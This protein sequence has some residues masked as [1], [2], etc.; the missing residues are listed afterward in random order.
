[1]LPGKCATGI[2]E[3]I[4]PG[5]RHDAAPILNRSAQKALERGEGL[6]QFLVDL[7]G[8]LPRRFRNVMSSVEGQEHG[9]EGHGVGQIV[10]RRIKVKSPAT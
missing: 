4:L 6:S 5:V 2:G 7:L 8:R 10:Q 1:M 3:R 9:D